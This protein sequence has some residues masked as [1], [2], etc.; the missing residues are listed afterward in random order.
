MNK[1]SSHGAI[2]CANDWA[3]WYQE[4]GEAIGEVVMILQGLTIPQ[5]REVL[6]NTKKYVDKLGY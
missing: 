4:Q 3:E 2:D 6:D 1:S 5:I